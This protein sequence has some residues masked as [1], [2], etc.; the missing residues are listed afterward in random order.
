MEKTQRDLIEYNGID[1]CRFKNLPNFR[2]VNLEHIF[3]IPDQK[4]NIEQVIKVWAE[5]CILDT[6]IVKTPVGTSLEGQNLTG[7]KMLACG[8]IRLK[9]EYVACEKAQ[10]VHT[11]HTTFPFCGYVVLSKD[12]N[13]NAIIKASVAIEDIFSEQIDLRCVYNNITMIIIADVC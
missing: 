2:E 5:A 9:I 13:P 3:C 4:P 12:T 1:K 10:S 8:D 7:Y 11:A 6:E